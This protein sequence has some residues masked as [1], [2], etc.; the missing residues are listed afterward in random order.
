MILFTLHITSKHYAD[1]LGVRD[2]NKSDWG[3]LCPSHD[4]LNDEYNWLFGSSKKLI[5]KY[6][7][8][9]KSKVPG[10]DLKTN[11]FYLHKTTVTP[12]FWGAL[13]KIS[14]ADMCLKFN[15]ILKQFAFNKKCFYIVQFEK[16][17]SGLASRL[18][19]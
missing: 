1:G 19:F 18:R 14:L 6:G 13:N 16:K 12:T 11:T 10:F 3:W 5:R 9:T 15:Q 8:F 7:Y 17:S 2:E 4:N